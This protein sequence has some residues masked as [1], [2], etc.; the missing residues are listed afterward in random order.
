MKVEDTECIVS[1]SFRMHKQGAQPGNESRVFITARGWSQ[2]GRQGKHRKLGPHRDC[3][4]L[5]ALARLAKLV[6]G[7]RSLTTLS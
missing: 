4:A 2:S 1:E 3:R 7:S 5:A 6:K